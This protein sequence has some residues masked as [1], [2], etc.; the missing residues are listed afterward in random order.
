MLSFGIFQTPNEAERGVDHLLAAG[1]TQGDVSVLLP[2][3]PA[4]SSANG[5]ASHDFAYQKSTLAPEGAATGATAGGLVGGTFGLLAGLGALAIP[6]IG[7]LLAIGPLVGALAGFGVG[8]AVGGMVGTLVGLGMPEYTARHLEGRVRDGG[9]L[10]V[11]HCD[12][13]AEID[14]AKA[15][16]KATGALDVSSADQDTT[17][18]EQVDA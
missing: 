15:S 9:T 14:T 10:V 13:E 6:G 17:L 2:D 11:V 3:R 5:T 12:T 1:F 18:I 4:D 8:G 16:L 7:P